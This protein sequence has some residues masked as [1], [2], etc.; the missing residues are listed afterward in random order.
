MQTV[1]SGKLVQVVR[2]V[3]GSTDVLQGFRAG[4]PTRKR[5]EALI[6][7]SRLPRLFDAARAAGQ[8]DAVFLH[9]PKTAGLS[10]VS[11]LRMPYLD[12][13]LD[14]RVRFCQRG[15]VTF[16][17]QSY[18]ALVAQGLV[19]EDFDKKSFKF[20]FVRNP[21]DRAVSLY[22]YLKGW[23]IPAGETFREF[24]MRIESADFEPIGVFNARG[25][26]Q[27]NPQVR[28][29]EGVKVDYLGRLE[30][31]AADVEK[32]CGQL[33][34]EAPGLP[35]VNR[36]KRKDPREMFDDRSLAAVRGY[37][38]EDF[39]RFGYSRDL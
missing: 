18:S 31:I 32:V 15:I 17:H 1:G 13:E 27:C 5:I 16:G 24:C 37:Y 22:S 14:V 36:S 9:V 2:R 30:S 34:I 35:H 4:R 6:L 29:L 38:Q 8:P 39:E 26:S 3:V 23:R 12:E 7:R 28:W 25:L 10:L 33:G 21:F 11:A 20:T 19:G